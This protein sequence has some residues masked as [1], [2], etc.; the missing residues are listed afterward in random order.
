M[1]INEDGESLLWRFGI[2]GI[3]ADRNFASGLQNRDA[4]LFDFDPFH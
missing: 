4:S 1:Q 2:R 3:D